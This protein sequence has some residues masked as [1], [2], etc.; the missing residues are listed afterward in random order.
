M[1]QTIL[2]LSALWLA[3]CG[4]PTGP[5]LAHGKP[6][7]HW[8]QA[9][10]DPDAKLRK[11]AADV[12]GNIGAADPAVVPALAGAVQDGD[13]AVRQAAVLALLKMGPD[14]RPATP[15]LRAACKDGDATV[16]SYATKALA[17]IE[18]SAP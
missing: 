11:R 15:A 1:R 13:R 16:R 2:A 18:A 7:E 14:A 12:L 10:R 4:G 8:V 3:G 6:V 5:M 17:K 9:L